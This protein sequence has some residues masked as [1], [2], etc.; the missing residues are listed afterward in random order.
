LIAN[1]IVDIVDEIT[2]SK[3]NNMDVEI[4]ILENQLNELVYQ[5]YELTPEEIEIIRKQT[6]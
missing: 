5:L 2:K 4:S 6:H 3:Q 1:N